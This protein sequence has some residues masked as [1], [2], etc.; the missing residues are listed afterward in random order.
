MSPINHSKLSVKRHGGKVE[1]YYEL[2]SLIDSTKEICSD[3]RHRILHTLWGVRRVI[4]PIYGNELI[5]SDGKKISVKEICEKDHII[6]DY[7]NKF[8]PTLSDFSDA[9]APMKDSD[10]VIINT[11]HEKSELSDLEYDILISPLAVTGNPSSLIFTHNTWFI[12]NILPKL[13]QRKCYPFE[14][15]PFIAAADIFKNMNF[16][17]W[18]DN[19][20]V[21]PP[22]LIRIKQ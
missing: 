5:N 17:M 4:I 20:L 15:I 13:S 2:H 21:N 9:L 1:D 16:E 22:S 11:I 10:K 12:Y 6:P 8:I 14:D 18:M 19:G 7:G 3:N